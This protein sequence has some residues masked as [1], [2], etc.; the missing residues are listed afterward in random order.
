MAG[1]SKPLVKIGVSKLKYAALSAYASNVTALLLANIASYPTPLPALAGVNGDIDALNSAITLWGPVGARGS[2]QNLLA[3]RQ[4]ALV[5]YTD[6][7]QLAAYVQNTVDPTTSYSDQAAFIALSGFGVKNPPSP[8]G[9][10]AAVQTF[11]QLIQAKI[12]PYTPKLKWKKPIG[13][14]SPGNV[15]AYQVFRGT[16]AA[17][18]SATLLA[19]TTKTSYVDT[20]AA[21]STIYWYWVVPINSAGSGV[22]SSAVNIAVPA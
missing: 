18:G 1:V 16:A 6:L 3:L 20:S 22:V 5:V 11:G 7:Q 19:V 8:Q 21:R 12:S 10:L 4:A 15:K 14:I 9:P 2:H 17:F 13:V